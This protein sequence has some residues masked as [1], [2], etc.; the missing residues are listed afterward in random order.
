MIQVIKKLHTRRKKVF[1]V[2]VDRT[3]SKDLKQFADGFSTVEAILSIDAETKVGEA[4]VTPDIAYLIRKIDCME[5]SRMAFVGLRLVT[6]RILNN[7]TDPQGLVSR[8]INE[9][10][11]ETYKVPNPLNIEFPTTACRL[12]REHPFVQEILNVQEASVAV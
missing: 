7:L 10:I 3:T 12:K 2:G 6:T 5:Q 11:L 1:I 9:G 4:I 8:A